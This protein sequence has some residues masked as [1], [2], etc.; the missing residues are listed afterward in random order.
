MVQ[1]SPVLAFYDPRKELV[2]ENDASEYSL[3]SAMLQNGVPVAFA[4]RIPTDTK[5][6]CAQI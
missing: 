5:R 2:L 4:S 3:G 6:R 1:N